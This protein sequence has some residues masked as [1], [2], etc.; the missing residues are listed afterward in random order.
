MIKANEFIEYIRS[1]EQPAVS[2]RENKSRIGGLVQSCYK[3][4]A[5]LD[6]L[7]VLMIENFDKPGVRNFIINY[8]FDIDVRQSLFYI[9]QLCYLSLVYSSPFLLKFITEGCQKSTE[10]FILV[11]SLGVLDH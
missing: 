10:F 6:V 3:R 8:L 9:P 11:E 7:F 1:V 5:S 4:S 2:K